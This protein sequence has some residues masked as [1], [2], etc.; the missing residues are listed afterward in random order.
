MGSVSAEDDRPT[1]DRRVRGEAT[2]PRRRERRLALATVTVVGLGLLPPV[3]AR[4]KAIAVLG[5]TMWPGF[6]RP[7]ASEVTRRRTTIQGV[8]GDVY[9]SDASKPAV[10]LV[11]GAAPRGRDDPR[12]VR[13]ARAIARAGRMVFVPA[14]DL[15]DKR[16]TEADLERIVTATVALGNSTRRDVVLLGI[17]YGGSLALIAATHE[18]AREHIVQ[19]ATFGAYFDLVGLIQAAST[20]VSI[21]GDERRRWRPGPRAQEV[22]FEA[23][24]QIA[25]RAQR[26][27]L[28]RALTG[29][30]SAS[31]LPSEARAVYE[32]VTNEDPDRTFELAERLDP[33]AR[34]VLERFSPRSVSER[35][36]VPLVALHAVDD[37]VTPF[38]EALRLE[39]NVDGARVLSVRLFD[40]VDFEGASIAKAIPEVFQLWRFTSWVLSAQE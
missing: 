15:Y 39:R 2:R 7:L 8:A 35:L 26:D 4:L 27:A 5:E 40:H 12:A 11:P 32:L 13:L 28:E 18:R 14:L 1:D 37:P 3:Q 22:L 31:E 29:R 33:R 16:F 38:A 6:P 24:V 21:V 25:P 23:A 20:N 36:D 9:E 10:V 17:S 19:I 30:A 34:S